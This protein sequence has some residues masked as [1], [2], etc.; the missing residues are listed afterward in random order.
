MLQ[1]STKHKQWNE[2]STAVY[3]MDKS[4]VNERSHTHKHF[5]YMTPFMWSTKPGK[6]KPISA[7]GAVSHEVGEWKGV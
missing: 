7:T 5:S 6:T 4:D 1:T 3:N 2:W